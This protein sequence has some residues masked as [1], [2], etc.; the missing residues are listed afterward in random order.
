MHCA[1]TEEIK[2]VTADKALIPVPD[3]HNDR[4]G[5]LDISHIV[6]H[7]ESFKVDWIE[8]ILN[9]PSLNLLLVVWIPETDVRV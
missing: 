8:A 2:G 6:Q 3:V 7:F 1:S 5:L 9:D 4:R